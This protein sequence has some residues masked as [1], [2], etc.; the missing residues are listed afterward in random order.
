MSDSCGCGMPPE[1]RTRFRTFLVGA[2]LAAAAA[3]FTGAFG[4]TS[5]ALLID[6]GLV[7]AG[8]QADSSTC[9]CGSG[10][11]CCGFCGPDQKQ[12]RKP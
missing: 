2:A 8:D 7:A 6:N 12:A 9:L 1:G 10:G 3:S 11:P 4:F 5:A